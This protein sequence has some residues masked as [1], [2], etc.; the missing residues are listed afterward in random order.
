MEKTKKAF[1]QPQENK[2]SVGTF[3]FVFV[4][5]L[6][7]YLAF[8]DIIKISFPWFGMDKL[9]E[10]PKSIAFLVL[11]LC[12]VFLYTILLHRLQR[13]L[14]NAFLLLALLVADP[15]IPLCFCT[16]RSLIIGV[17]LVVLLLLFPHINFKTGVIL[18]GIFTFL[19]AFLDPFAGFGLLSVAVFA[20][21][22]YYCLLD[23]S[24][25]GDIL[26]C[27][28]PLTALGG[29][30]VECFAASFCVKINNLLYSGLDIR[31]AANRTVLF[32]FLAVLVVLEILF[33][34]ACLRSRSMQGNGGVLALCITLCA[35]PIVGF[36]LQKGLLSFST[37]TLSFSLSI[38]L[39][40]QAGVE[41]AK[42]IADNQ[43]IPLALLLMLFLSALCKPL[44]IN[45][46]ELLSAMVEF[47][48]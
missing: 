11:A 32:V 5:L 1:I 24:A 3:L 34:R 40:R 13:R 22:I 44:F 46:T 17:A 25:K 37:L 19:T 23:K 36:V 4:F 47:A 29:I 41:P 14:Q 18:T 33:F 16:L 9:F 43:N 30:L 15:F 7:K 42:K 35:L 38:L 20:P 8:S 45:G 12:L 28:P 48:P 31:L 2:R 26:F 27:I 21:Y 39:L 6:I 10:S